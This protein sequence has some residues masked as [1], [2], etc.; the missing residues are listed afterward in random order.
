MDIFDIL[1]PIMVG[2][3]SSHTAGAVRIGNVGY[4]LLGEPV[5]EAIITLHGSF[6]STGKGHGTDRALLS[7]LMDMKPDDPR[8]PDAFEEAKKHGMV[9]RFQNDD[10]GEVHPNTAR[11]VLKGKSGGRL[12]MEACSVG[13]GRIRVRRVH[14]LAVDFS[15]ER[16]T[17]VLPHTDRPGV[18]AKVTDQLAAEGINIAAMQVFRGSRGGLAIMVIETD[19]LVSEEVRGRL[20]ARCGVESVTYLGESE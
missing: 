16:P 17:M 14:G 12:E 18:V 3:S 6:A 1:G 4:H 8:I 19:Q 11:L 9:Y 13:G 5:A 7:G 10:L 2:P 15:G 20:L